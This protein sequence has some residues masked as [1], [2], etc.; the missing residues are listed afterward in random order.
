MEPADLL[1]RQQQSESRIQPQCGHPWEG[2]SHLGSERPLPES[3]SHLSMSHAVSHTMIPPFSKTDDSEEIDA[4]HTKIRKNGSGSTTINS[5]R[6]CYSTPRYD[7][8]YMFISENN[9]SFSSKII[10]RRLVLKDNL[11]RCRALQKT[12]SFPGPNCKK[13]GHTADFCV[14]NL[15]GTMT[16][17]SID[18][19]RSAQHVAATKAPPAATSAPKTAPE[20]VVVGGATYHPS[21]S[22]TR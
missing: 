14:S 19:T 7:D 12:A 6:S 8:N 15:G 22:D 5:Y 13:I 10:I 4:L 21:W 18:D 16:G 3:V 11:M 2:A 9:P 1:T 17:R 20:A